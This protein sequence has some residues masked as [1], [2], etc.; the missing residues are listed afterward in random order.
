MKNPTP[1]LN[2]ALSEAKAEFPIVYASKDV[3]FKTNTG[4][5]I[6]FTYAELEEIVNLVAPVLSKHGL[7]VTHEPGYHEVAPETY[8]YG[9]LTCLLHES[10]EERQAFISLSEDMGNDPKD[11]ASRLSY[12]RRYNE[13]AILDIVVV[14]PKNSE[15]WEETKRKLAKEVRQEAGLVK[16]PEPHKKGDSSFAEAISGYTPQKSSTHE[17]CVGLRPQNSSDIKI[18]LTTLG[19]EQSRF[20]NWYGQ[21]FNV[22]ADMLGLEQMYEIIRAICKVY[23]TEK[24]N[25]G[26]IAAINNVIIDQMTTGIKLKDALKDW[27]NRFFKQNKI[28]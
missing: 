13:M 25:V 9:L 28:A 22:A 21:K 15:Q 7:V 5:S 8:K 12:A 11:W 6:R 10:G 4:R 19:F 17:S 16:K 14:E 27:L 3:D 26:A 1:S 23:G 18:L 2:K 24:N 20:D